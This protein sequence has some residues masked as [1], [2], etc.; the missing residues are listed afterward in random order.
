MEVI[1]HDNKILVR[2]ESK[3]GIWYQVRPD[4]CPCEDFTYRGLE[5]PCKHIVAAQNYM[6]MNFYSLRSMVKESLLRIARDL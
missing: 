3:P 2:S 6:G 4:F 1:V 5:R